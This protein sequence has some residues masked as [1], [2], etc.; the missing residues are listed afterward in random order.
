MKTFFQILTALF[1]TTNLAAQAPSPQGAAAA[2]EGIV[3]SHMQDMIDG[4]NKKDAALFGKHMADELDFIPPNAFHSTSK[5]ELQKIHEQLFRGPLKNSIWNNVEIQA[6]LLT[7]NVATAILKGS[8]TDV[9]PAT[10]K[11]ASFRGV[12]SGVLLKE[13]GDWKF[14]QMQVTSVPVE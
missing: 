8:S 13:G 4:F 12:I 11:E 1:L 7:D 3:R 6:K 5:M 2:D 10:G 9:D 14:I